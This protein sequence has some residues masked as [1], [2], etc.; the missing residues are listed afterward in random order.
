MKPS[1]HPLSSRPLLR[2]WSPYLFSL[3]LPLGL[4]GDDKKLNPGQFEWHPGDSPAGP[5]LVVVDRDD[6]LAMVY[7]NGIEIARTT[8]STGKPGHETPTGVF[9]VLEKDAQHRSSTYNDAPMPYMQR[10]TWD[11]IALH[12]GQLPGYPAS[13][14]CVRLPFDFSKKLYSITDK[15]LTVVITSHSAPPMT[16][17]SAYALLSHLDAAAESAAEEKGLF[18]RVKE[19]YW[20]PGEEREGHLAIVISGRDR[21]VHALRNGVQIGEAPVHFDADPAS[22]PEGVFL[23]LDHLEKGPSPL[24]PKKPRHRWVLLGTSAAHHAENVWNFSSRVHL[25]AEF[26]DNLYGALEPGTLLMFTPDTLHP[27]RRSAR[28]FA[29]AVSEQ[30][31]REA[32]PKGQEGE[33]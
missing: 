1:H 32:P 3:F 20:K 19:T 5:V 24:D 4:I 14:G 9:Q 13:H 30:H 8:V 10:L 2:G 16:S 28:G 18:G 25:P 15:G 11:G 23:M 21:K 27:D 22:L 17:P 12:A 6:Q 33:G 7:R 31:T 29:V 26:A